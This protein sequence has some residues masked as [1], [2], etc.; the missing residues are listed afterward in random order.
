M[1]VGPYHWWIK[2]N[3]LRKTMWY[4]YYWRLT[5]ILHSAVPIRLPFYIRQY[6]PTWRSLP[7]LFAP[8]SVQS[9]RWLGR[10]ELSCCKWRR[11]IYEII[12]CLFSI[13]SSA[14]RGRSTVRNIVSCWSWVNKNKF[15]QHI[16]C[17]LGWK[18]DSYERSKSH[19]PFKGL[20]F[21]TVGITWW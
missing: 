21:W 18:T 13:L 9:S 20:C 11:R 7:A 2:H 14:V 10:W 8:S 19:R 4:H 16:L 3:C 6:S 15:T 5:E 17:R 12:I 1:K